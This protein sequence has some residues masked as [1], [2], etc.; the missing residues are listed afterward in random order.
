M[1]M[2]Q[3]HATEARAILLALLAENPKLPAVTREV[4]T[5][6]ASDTAAPA[7][8]VLGSE[9]DTVGAVVNRVQTAYKAALAEAARPTESAE[10]DDLN[11]IVTLAGKLARLIR[12]SLPGDQVQIG[13]VA[14]QGDRMKDVFLDVGWHSLRPGGY[15]IHHALAV[16]DV[17]EWAEKKAREHIERLPVRSVQKKKRRGDAAAAATATAVSAFVRHLAWQFGREFGRELRGTI[18][19][20]AT[21]VF[22]LQK[23]LDA[24]N[25]EAILKNRPPVFIPPT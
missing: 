9:K 7:W 23:P 14:L 20:V 1:T 22:D 10:R 8:R 5:A 11:E 15:G 16:T 18:G 17:L 2:K 4:M 13:A 12:T 6:L 25:V 19:H 21:A 24:S 3:N